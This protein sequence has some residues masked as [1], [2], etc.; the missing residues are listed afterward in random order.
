[1]KRHYDFLVSQ[2]LQALSALNLEQ[3]QRGSQFKIEDLARVPQTPVS[4]NFRKILILSVFAGV[5]A[6]ALLAVGLEIADTSF[7]SQFELE[8]A[9]DLP[10]I[11]SVPSLSL[12]G[13]IAKKRAGSFGKTIVYLVWIS[14]IGLVL[15]DQ[16]TEGKIFAALM[17][18]LN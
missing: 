1:L 12:P 15:V 13:E 11:C 17:Q 7:K 18:N 6:G 4:P 8:Q 2:N 3:N 14:A 16:R 10:V 5:M 9:F